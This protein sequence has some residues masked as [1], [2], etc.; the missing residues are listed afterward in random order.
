MSSVLH[1][2]TSLPDVTT[3]AANIGVGL[4]AVTAVVVGA[5]S[6]TKA[7]KKSVIDA[8]KPDDTATVTNTQVIGGTLQ[9]IYGAQMLVMEI[10]RNTQAVNESAEAGHEAK[11]ALGQVCEQLRELRHQNERLIDEMRRNASGR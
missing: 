2:V 4:A 1:S 9:D 5:M 11:V 6:A 8:L 7:I 10:S 3:F